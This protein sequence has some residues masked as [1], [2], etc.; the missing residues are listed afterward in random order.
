MLLWPFNKYP[1]TD[2]ETFNWEWLLKTVKEWVATM[3]TFKNTITAA[4]DAMRADW[5]GFE[6]SMTDDWQDYQDDLNDQWQEFIDDTYKDQITE[7]LEQHP[8]WTTTVMDGAITKEKINNAF[9]P[10]IYKDYVTPEMFGAV[11]DGVTDDTTAINA[12]IA[13][14]KTKNMLFV[15]KYIKLQDDID[16]TGCR[17]LINKIVLNDHDVLLGGDVPKQASTLMGY[18]DDDQHINM[19]EMVSAA[20]TGNVYIRNC[21]GI[22]IHIGSAYKVCFRTNNIQKYIGYSTFDFKYV[23]TIDIRPDVNNPDGTPNNVSSD[24]ATY[25][26]WMNENKIVLNRCVNFYAFNGTRF[27]HN[28]IQ[29]G[30]FEGSYEIN[31][32][33]ATSNKFE[34][35]R[36]E[37]ANDNNHYIKLGKGT[38]NNR[39]YIPLSYRKNVSDNGVNNVF[40]YQELSEAHP[41]VSEMVTFENVAANSLK[42]FT[43]LSDNNDGTFSITGASNSVVWLSPFLDNPANKYFAVYACANYYAIPLYFEL[44]DETHTKITDITSALYLLTTGQSAYNNMTEGSYISI[45]NPTC[46]CDGTQNDVGNDFALILPSDNW[47]NLS[48]TDR[49]RIKYVR[50]GIKQYA[51]FHSDQTIFKSLAVEVGDTGGLRSLKFHPAP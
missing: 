7:I 32:N 13:E 16:L 42:G 29:G 22:H 21:H 31:L 6:T 28:W 33:Y 24:I 27:D 49:N 12:A 11:S 14:A 37:T 26:N 25:G 36:L 35:P 8:E 4:W 10:Y 3:Q 17:C 41:I 46:Q 40:C 48:S 34:F 9:L 15:A 23:D 2:Y 51:Y 45:A 19:I 1:G 18:V 47:T 39:I 20:D 43:N 5:Q 44:Y 50:F 38:R 30:C